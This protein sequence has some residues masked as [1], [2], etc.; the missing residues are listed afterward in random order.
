[1]NP[2]D[3]KVKDDS[4]IQKSRS[5]ELGDKITVVALVV[6]LALIVS[7]G[8][9]VWKLVNSE[10]VKRMTVLTTVPTKTKIVSSRD[11][12]A[13]TL[14]TSN[15]LMVI[16]GTNE[17]S[18]PKVLNDL[19]DRYL[20]AKVLPGTE[21]KSEMLAPPEAKALLSNS[22]AVSIPA[23]ATSTL[24]SQLRVGDMID[25]LA[26]PA[27]QPSTGQSAQSKPPKFENLLV[28]NVPI[29][30]DPKPDEKYLAEVG[31]ITLALPA[32]R[33]DEFASSIAGATIVITRRVSV[34]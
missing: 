27:N 33:R 26:I 3:D 31:A 8:V 12:E 21:I 22:V 10:Q 20:L 6:L 17:T 24:G 16:Q 30:K 9:M 34:K 4:A 1:M 2:A 23:T 7:A 25:L 14:L 28:L 32:T 15:H 11:L 29:K 18:D 5:I 13:Y 19:L